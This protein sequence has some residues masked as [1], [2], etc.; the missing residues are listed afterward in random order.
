MFASVQCK[1][2]LASKLMFGQ[3]K[4]LNFSNIFE[5]FLRVLISDTASEDSLD[6]AETSDV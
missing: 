2:M 5:T 4:I 6:G 1:V 3:H